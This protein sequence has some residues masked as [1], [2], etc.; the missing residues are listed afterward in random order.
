MFRCLSCGNFITRLVRDYLV[1]SSHDVHLRL[2]VKQ[3]LK[4]RALIGDDRVAKLSIVG[5][6]MRSHTGIASILFQ[7][8]AQEGIAI[9]LI[10]T[11]EIKLSVVIDEKYLELGARA[12]HT[13]FNM[14][15][16]KT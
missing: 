10:A 1:P 7:T 16:G 6:G 9:Q 14:E 15:A 11:S 3:E 5:V 8:L 12:L 4:A 2:L 13:A